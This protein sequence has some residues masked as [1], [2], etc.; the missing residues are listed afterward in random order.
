MVGAQE[1]YFLL[2]SGGPCCFLQT[3]L[4]LYPQPAACASQSEIKVRLHRE[5]SSTDTGSNL[6]TAICYMRRDNCLFIAMYS[7]EFA[8]HE[9]R[10]QSE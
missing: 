6:L 8:A 9:G 7:K 10:R 3:E 2:R 4:N 1:Q 5:I